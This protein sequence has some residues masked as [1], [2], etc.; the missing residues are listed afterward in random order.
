MELGVEQILDL[1]SGPTGGMIAL[2]FGVGV[3]V[4]WKWFDV[5][6]S[7]RYK[8]NVSIIK[9]SAEEIKSYLIHELES[10]RAEMKSQDETCKKDLK[11]LSDKLYDIM[12]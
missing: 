4:T 10:L 8:E 1:L 11:E 12:K 5:R 2:S 6:S 9:K 3:K 7:E